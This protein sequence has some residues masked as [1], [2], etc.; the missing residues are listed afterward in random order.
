MSEIILQ[1]LTIKHLMENGWEYLE[2]KNLDDIKKNFK[3]ILVERNLKNFQKFGKKT[4][5]EK[6]FNRFLSLI[7]NNNTFSDY[8]R[9]FLDDD[10]QITTDEGEN[11]YLNI[12]NKRKWCENIFQVG[13]EISNNGKRHD[14]LLFINGLPIANIEM[15]R[16]SVSIN[17]AFNQTKEY[18][19]ILTSLMKFI[20]LFIISN[21][22]ETRYY[23]NNEQINQK[24]VFRYSDKKNRPVNDIYKFIEEFL[25]VCTF[26]KYI[27]RYIINKKEAKN[28]LALRGY[29]VHGAEQAI[30]HLESSNTNGYLWH[31]TGSGKTITSFKVAQIVSQELPQF[32]KVVFLV[33]RRDL[34]SQTINEY[35]SFL[36][37]HNKIQETKNS[38]ILLKQ[39]SSS[40]SQ[41]KLIITTIQKMNNLLTSK[42]EDIN[43]LMESVQEKHFVFIIDECHRSQFG[44]MNNN[45]KQKIKN[46]RYI[47]FTGTP[48][49]GDESKEERQ[50]QMTTDL[51]FGK[52]LHKYLMPNAIEDKNVLAF[53]VF[54]HN[55][56]ESLDNKDL[57]N[58]LKS[59][60]YLENIAE[61]IIFN[62]DRR[63]INKKYS[64]LAVLENVDTLIK[65]YEILKQK[66]SE[67]KKNN[68]QYKPIKIAATFSYVEDYS[69]TNSFRRESLK[70]IINDFNENTNSNEDIN[71]VSNYQNRL[72][73]VI[74][75][76]HIEPEINVTL[77]VDQL[78][79]GFDAKRLNT[80][81]IV[82]NLKM[83]SLIQAISRTNRVYSLD[84]ERGQVISYVPGFK[85]NVEEA[86]KKYSNSSNADHV[87]KRDFNQLVSEAAKIYKEINEI[88][89][90]ELI[91]NPSQNIKLAIRYIKSVNHLSEYF[92]II[93]TIS[94]YNDELIGKDFDIDGLNRMVK[95]SKTIKEVYKKTPEWDE[96]EKKDGE[97]PLDAVDIPIYVEDVDNIDADYIRVLLGYATSSLAK[98]DVE[99][100]KEQIEEI[101]RK[102]ELV[103]DGNLLFEVFDEL[104]K[105]FN[106]NN[107]IE[108]NATLR[109][110]FNYKQFKF[111]NEYKIKS[112]DIENQ[113]YY[114]KIKERFAS[115]IIEEWIQNSGKIDGLSFLKRNEV[116]NKLR[117]DINKNLNLFRSREE[118]MG[119]LG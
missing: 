4:M 93:R 117:L 56:K 86:V 15:K 70:E 82:K 45:I 32:E 53:Q 85:N 8:A 87:I 35:N 64:A 97:N 11:I 23:A 96:I 57:H 111:K 76:E 50:K 102:I 3:K 60:K 68:P 48:V 33:D 62:F 101:K 99:A 16:S 26:S 55:E 47:G 7:E 22:N 40:S 81:Y 31:A 36:G 29:Q 66:Q 24:Y 28:L 18:S 84:K 6:E 67:R 107:K 38:R 106:Q 42:N 30:R 79:T 13:E 73:S 59:Q 49:F 61:D 10:N 88:D 21:G 43:K 90:E 112:K 37:K 105:R 74:K 58:L 41:D 39:L 5:S 69:D 51:I 72:Q 113:L 9:F 78:L 108:I 77:V 91:K 98:G 104:L 100:T 114:Y 25:E 54:Y 27:S 20:Q 14:I 83:H 34:D 71:N 116:T 118:I 89:I 65:F 63:S 12:F 46:V 19:K 80:I 92:R 103:E 1:N 17:N 44:D 2:V 52:C 75:K 109:E 95:H 110:I 94:D 115:N 119:D